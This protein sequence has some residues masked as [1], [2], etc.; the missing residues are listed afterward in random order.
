MNI[1]VDVSHPAHVHFFRFA[2]G[3]WKQRG[4]AVKIVARDKDLT[5]A[6][7]DKYNLDYTCL[8]RA[9][10]GAAGLAMEL[11]EH[12]TRLLRMA[13]AFHPEVMLNIGGTFIVHA[14]KVLRVPTIVFSDTEIAV[15]ANRITYP[16]ATAICTPS[17]Y[18]HALGAKQVRYEGY[19][20][21]AYTHPAWF[22]PNPDVLTEL[23]LKA[24]ERLFVVRFINWQAGHDLR[25]SGFSLQGKRHLID[26]LLQ[27][28]RVVVT[29][30][31]ELPPDL[32]Q[33]QMQI[34]PTKIHDLLAFS[35]LYIGESAT[36]ASESALLGTPF[37][38]VSP[39]RRGYTDEEEKRYQLGC[40][41]TPME[42]EAAIALAGKWILRENL[43]EEWQA[44]RQ[45]LLNEKIDVTG[46]MVNFVEQFSSRLHRHA[47]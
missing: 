34:S 43:D 44:K 8:S 36:M 21:L 22:R 41:F 5:L 19:Q 10:R 47:T 25:Q 38:L 35:T 39:T 13:R 6:L 15:T 2:I 1:L 42:E 27:H 31:S 14:G 17:C 11:V 26:F 23:G 16:F 30:E 28:G 20:E 46:W 24:G 45:R 18:E 40:T 29:S 4:H 32:A 3:E 37:I 33:F 9:R 12:E 7:L